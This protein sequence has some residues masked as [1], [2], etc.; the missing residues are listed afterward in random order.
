MGREIEYDDDSKP[1]PEPLHQR[2]TV[3]EEQI[4]EI[5]EI[6]A[7]QENFDARTARELGIG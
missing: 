1:L 2:V 7:R 6:L 5:M 3:V 4:R